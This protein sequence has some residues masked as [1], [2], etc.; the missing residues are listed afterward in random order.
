MTSAYSGDPKLL[1]TNVTLIEAFQAGWTVRQKHDYMETQIRKTLS[2]ALAS[3]LLSSGVFVQDY[4][5]PRPDNDQNFPML[6]N[7]PGRHWK[8]PAPNLGAFDLLNTN[9]S[10]KP[11]TPTGLQ[12][13]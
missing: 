11:P 7:A 12:V 9:L 6:I 5:C 3:P 2:P 10:I 4:D 1:K 8:L 13:F